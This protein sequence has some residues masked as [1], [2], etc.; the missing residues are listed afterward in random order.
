M[1]DA[2][3]N[4]A[5]AAPETIQ[6]LQ[7]GVPVALAMLAGMRL[8]IFTAL[9]EGPHSASDLARRL[10]VAEERLSR[11]LHALVMAGLLERNG[12]GFANT[13]ESARYLVKGQ[14]DYMGDMH[15]LL[16]HLWHADLQTAQS[17][18][19]G[20]PARLHDYE[21]ASD[22]D[23][24]VMLRGMHGSAVSAGRDLASRFDFSQCRSV[25]DI[26]GGTGGLAAALCAANPALNGT[27]FD[28]PRTATL[29][30]SILEGTPG[31]E[32]VTIEAGNIV[33]E[34]PRATYDAVVLRALVQVLA[35]GDAARA[36]A[37]AAAATRIG[38]TITIMGGG[39]LD[40]D[41]LG[42][43][44]A[45]ALNVTLMNLYPAG[46][47]YTEAEH[48]AW[49]EAAGCGAMRRVTLPSGSGIIRAIRL[50]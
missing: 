1:S 2:S 25:A 30:A 13:A 20:K 28:L 22:E 8:E 34:R 15:E 37:H 31:S 45:V 42:P 12:E 7:A 38:G 47:A 44:S 19:S 4:P 10:G 18:R 16:K 32:R 33:A 26:G 36:I 46:G 17:I 41:R 24:T 39:I 35:P 6:R 9:A 49:L 23:M 3:P 14:P 5:N 50:R 29:A 21:A 27:L 11:L 43:R 40:D 48:K